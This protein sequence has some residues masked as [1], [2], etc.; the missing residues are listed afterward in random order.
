MTTKG[1][2][3]V[4]MKT[5][6]WLTEE[7]IEIITETANDIAKAK[8]YFTT[9]K[10]GEVELVVQAIYLLKRAIKAKKK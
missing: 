5:P 6:Y 3:E 7:G 8:G 9:V 10:E 1:Q 2:N 4:R